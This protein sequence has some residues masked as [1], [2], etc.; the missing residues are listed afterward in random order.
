MKRT[1][2]SL[3][4]DLAWR[5]HRE[6][7]QRETSVSE[8]VREVLAERFDMVAGRPRKIAFAGIVRRGETNVAERI[9]EILSTEWPAAI[10]QD[11]DR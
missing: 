2:I 10:D 3:P 4:E 8:V 5:L 6:A 7:R 1:T 11:R 9:E